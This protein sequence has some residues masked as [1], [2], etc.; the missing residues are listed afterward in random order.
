[1]IWMNFQISRKKSKKPEQAEQ[2]EIRSGL[3]RISITWRICTKRINTDLYFDYSKKKKLSR[4]IQ[5]WKLLM[6]LI[7]SMFYCKTDRASQHVPESLTKTF[8]KLCLHSTSSADYPSIWRIFKNKFQLQIC[9]ILSFIW[10]L[11]GHPVCINE[12]IHVKRTFWYKSRIQ[13]HNFDWFRK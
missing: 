10:D 5:F 4:H 6:S 11:L 13:G 3:L 1:M 7:V 12:S 2:T 8:V 9:V